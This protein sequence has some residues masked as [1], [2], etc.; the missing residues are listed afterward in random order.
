MTK[1]NA[2]RQREWRERQKAKKQCAYGGCPNPVKP[3]ATSCDEHL[4]QAREKRAG[5][6]RQLRAEV[7]ILR[8][9]NAEL[10]GRIAEL[11]ARLAEASEHGR[12]QLT[13]GVLLRE[14]RE[15]LGT[16]LGF[17]RGGLIPANLIPPAVEK[18]RAEIDAMR[19][20]APET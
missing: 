19:A 18:I 3:P 10:R 15:L 5:Q 12:L 13:H 8:I 1:S 9:E 17:Y 11:E 14:H 4:Q 7:E 6:V 20:A 16:V 2:Q